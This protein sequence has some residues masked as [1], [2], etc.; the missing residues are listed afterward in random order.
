[1]TNTVNASICKFNGQDKMLETLESHSFHEA[2]ME[3]ESE[4]GKIAW[5]AHN[6]S[7][8]PHTHFQVDGHVLFYLWS[9][10]M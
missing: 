5:F 3:E 10:I 6:L 8:F 9:T 7:S 1:M 4:G 2:E